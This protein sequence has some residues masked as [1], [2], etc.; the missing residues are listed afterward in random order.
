[1][2]ATLFHRH[3]YCRTERQCHRPP[4]PQKRK[5][6]LNRILYTLCYAYSPW[7]SHHTQDDQYYFFLCCSQF[8]CD[9]KAIVRACASHIILYNVASAARCS[10]FVHASTRMLYGLYYTDITEFYTGLLLRHVAAT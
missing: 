4:W 1:M 2:S 9:M 7:P 10:Q 6:N 3:I 5:H 8:M